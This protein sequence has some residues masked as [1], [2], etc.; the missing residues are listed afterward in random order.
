MSKSKTV[1]LE[2]IAEA[3]N[4]THPNHIPVGKK[5]K[6]LFMEEPQIG[7]CFCVGWSYRTSTVKEVMVDNTFRTHN[8]IYKWTIYS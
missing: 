2:K 1:I 4:P 7:F 5:V 3:P 6:G 8:S